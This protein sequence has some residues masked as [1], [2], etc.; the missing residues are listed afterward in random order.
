PVRCS[1]ANMATGAGRWLES[2][3]NSKSTCQIFW[4]RSKLIG[5]P[6]QALDIWVLNRI[7]DLVGETEF[8]QIAEAA[9]HWPVRLAADAF[10]NDN[11]VVTQIGV[12]AQLHPLGL[13]KLKRCARAFP[14]CDAGFFG[15]W[16][17]PQRYCT[18]GPTIDGSNRYPA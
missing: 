9:I 7:N 16:H 17:G 15:V 13:R 8:Q 11:I 10:G 12:P 1:L 5:K 4:K 18:S 14:T 2:N 3:R 6:A